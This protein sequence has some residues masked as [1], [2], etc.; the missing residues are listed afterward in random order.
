MCGILY[1]ILK[2][3][4]RANLLIRSTTQVRSIIKIAYF[5][6]SSSRCV[7]TVV[8]WKRMVANVHKTRA[9]LA[10]IKEDSHGYGGC[11]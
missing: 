3:K 1:V 9:W 10:Q 5:L 11:G 8:I 7:R 4:K 6:A 2:K